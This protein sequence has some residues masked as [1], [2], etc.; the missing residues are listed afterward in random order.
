MKFD[1]AFAKGLL[2]TVAS[3][4]PCCYRC[5]P[6]RPPKHEMVPVDASSHTTAPSPGH[7]GLF[8][9]RPPPASSSPTAAS[10][11]CELVPSHHHFLSGAIK[12]RRMVRAGPHLRL[13]QPC[14][15]LTCCCIGTCCSWLP[16]QG[17]A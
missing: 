8:P 17:A 6:T 11:T 14:W 12:L 10:R 15:S 9:A 13:K 5:L 2:A 3:L 7:G 1:P 4:F 16:V